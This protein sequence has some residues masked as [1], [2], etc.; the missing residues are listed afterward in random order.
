MLFV[1]ASVGVGGIIRMSGGIWLFVLRSLYRCRII[2]GLSESESGP[3]GLN[4]G[5]QAELGLI[6]VNQI[7]GSLSRKGSR[8]I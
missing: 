6:R 5:N 4:Q 3:I 1:V 7:E 8:G 2:T